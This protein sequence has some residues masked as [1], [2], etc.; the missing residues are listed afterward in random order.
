MVRPPLPDSLWAA[1]ARPAPETPPLV[2]EAE[3]DVAIVGGGFTGLSAALHAAEG[4]AKV[5]LVET[6]EP[7]FGASGRNGGQVIPGLKLSPDEIVAKFGAERGEHLNSY[8]GGVADLVFDLIER[9][10]IDCNAFRGGWLQGVH[11]SKA[12]PAAEAR[13][14]QWQARGA[15]VS[16]LDRQE[17][18][19]LSG[20]K[21]YVGAVCDSRG[22][23]LNPLGYARGLAAAAI[24]ARALVHGASPATGLSPANKG[25]QVTTPQGSVRAEQVLICTNGYTDG[26]WPGLQQSIIPLFSY[27]VAT[28]PLSDNLRKSIM[29]E[30]HA[31]SDT[32]RLLN[33]CRLDPEGRLVVGGRGAFR[34]TS[35]PR[36]FQPVVA[37]LRRL[38]PHVEDQ[39]FAFYWGG[40][41]ALTTSHLPH[42][43]ELAPGLTA[44]L[45]YNGR[46]VA[47]AS[48]TGK[49]LAKRV[50]GTPLDQLPFPQRPV[51]PIPLH[52]LRRPVLSALVAWKRLR[53]LQEAGH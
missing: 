52:G 41:I 7:G 40:R 43:A 34:D 25:W 13:V 3:A 47:M 50:L 20:A 29:P 21:G 2:G 14:R 6:A 48:A 22:G 19:R 24:K 28:R 12:L 31:L 18:E 44:A 35:D 38:F 23:T 42:F 8:A 51:K 11:S 30:G 39:D 5:V 9:H 53:D 15:A 45:G 46:G 49:E 10:G 37:A 33:Y 32:R 17:T 27:Q 1:T 4:G 16:L 36:F 26:L